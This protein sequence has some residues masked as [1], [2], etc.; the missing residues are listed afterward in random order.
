MSHN[1][2]SAM[3]PL[4]LTVFENYLRLDDRPAYPMTIPVE[5]ELQGEVLPAAFEAAWEEA[6][7]RHPLF[8]CLLDTSTKP[9]PSWKYCPE[10]RSPIDWGPLEAPRSCQR[11]STWRDRHSA[12][13]REGRTL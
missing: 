8:S 1:Y 7:Q 12:L 11:E 4:P 2:V 13:E 3:F 5:I 6:I 10:A 9:L